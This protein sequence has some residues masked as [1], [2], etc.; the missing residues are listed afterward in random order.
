MNDDHID[1]VLELED[2]VWVDILHSAQAWVG[3]PNA[4]KAKGASD[5]TSEN[6]DNR[7]GRT[8]LYNDSD[9]SEEE[10]EY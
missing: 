3:I 2:E 5:D 8:P 9:S 10:F 7:P 6:V 1:T 4:Q